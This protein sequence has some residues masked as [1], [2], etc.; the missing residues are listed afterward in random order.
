[1]LATSFG[2]QYLATS[3]NSGPWSNRSSLGK[4]ICLSPRARSANNHSRNTPSDDIIAEYVGVSYAEIPPQIVRQMLGLKLLR[5][6]AL[7]KPTILFKLIKV[8]D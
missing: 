8:S 6:S 3:R 7:V 1:V 5:V 2:L 4:M